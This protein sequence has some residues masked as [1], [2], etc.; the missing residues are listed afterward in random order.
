MKLIERNSG[1]N[2]QKV[3]ERLEMKKKARLKLNSLNIAH[4]REDQCSAQPRAD[5][6]CKISKKNIRNCLAKKVKKIEKFKEICKN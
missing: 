1:K 5:F 3:R 2:N 6:P 4:A